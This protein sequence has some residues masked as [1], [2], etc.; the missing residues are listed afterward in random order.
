MTGAVAVVNVEDAKKTAT[1]DVAKMLQDRFPQIANS[2]IIR[3][4]LEVLLISKIK[5]SHHSI[6]IIHFS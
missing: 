1:Y 6:I 4:T 5:L 3:R 2:A